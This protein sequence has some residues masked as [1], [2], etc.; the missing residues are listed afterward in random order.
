MNNEAKII[1][2]NEQLL[3]NVNIEKSK[4]NDYGKFRKLIG[5]QNCDGK[6]RTLSHSK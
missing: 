3:E 4:E 1:I 6:R 2:F 5:Y